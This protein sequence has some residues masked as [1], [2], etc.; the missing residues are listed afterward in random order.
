MLPDHFAV[1]FDGWSC[2]STH[3]VG[4]FVTFP[5]DTYNGSR[6]ILP[7]LAPM[8]DETTRDAEEN[9]NFLQSFL[10]IFDKDSSNP[11]SL[12]G[13]NIS[14]NRECSRFFQRRFV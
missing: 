4:V 3:Y 7:G 11:S 5:S 14:T 9:R 10:S 1:M 13:E 8:E 6:K 2:G 12:T